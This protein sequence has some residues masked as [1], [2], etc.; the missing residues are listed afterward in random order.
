MT[1]FHEPLILPMHTRFPP[2]PPK[3]ALV[4]IALLSAAN[5]RA[6]TNDAN[7]LAD[8]Q[9][10]LKDASAQLD[11]AQADADR[12]QRGLKSAQESLEQAQREVEKKRAQLEQATQAK[13]KADEQLA[14]M[15]GQYKDARDVIEKLYDARQQR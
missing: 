10:R 4:L 5:A 11:R 9:R 7:T 13:A 3:A 14:Q 6:D 2:A 8:A 15:Q 12:A 1:A